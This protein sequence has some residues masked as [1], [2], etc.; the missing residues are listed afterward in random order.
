MVDKIIP[1]DINRPESFMQFEEYMNL[2]LLNPWAYPN[3]YDTDAYL[4]ILKNLRPISKI[5]YYLIKRIS[6]SNPQCI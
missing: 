4:E 3:H 2:K 1:Y 5:R 6:G